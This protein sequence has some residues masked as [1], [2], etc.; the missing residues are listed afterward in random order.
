MVKSSDC[1]SEGPEFNSQQPHGGS[2]PS[3]MTYPLLVCL[4]TVTVYL[5]IN[6]SLRKRKRE[7]VGWHTPALSEQRQK[8]LW[9]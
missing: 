1:S 9:F 6:K 4:M 5:H 3:V 7:G 8:G 2:P